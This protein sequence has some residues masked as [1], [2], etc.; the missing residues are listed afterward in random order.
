M[1]EISF[2]CPW[3]LVVCVRGVPAHLHVGLIRK[4]KLPAITP[5][6]SKPNINAFG[7]TQCSGSF[8]SHGCPSRIDNAETT[9][10]FLFSV[11]SLLSHPDMPLPH[12]TEC[13]WHRQLWG[14]GVCD[15]TKGMRILSTKCG[16]WEPLDQMLYLEDVIAADPAGTCFKVTLDKEKRALMYP[17][18]TPTSISSP[19]TKSHA[20]SILAT[21]SDLLQPSSSLGFCCSCSIS[22]A[23]IVSLNCL[24][25]PICS[26]RSSL[27][28]AF[29]KS[30]TR[31]PYPQ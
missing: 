8:T 20:F 2:T 1:D 19:I 26:Y 3:N 24:G 29:Y 9:T 31:L 22:L 23:N 14:P 7:I 5:C 11:C 12:E 30:R 18:F 25:S 27:R 17:S 21:C 28:P 13:K 16:L 15:D 10:L 6:N 4:G